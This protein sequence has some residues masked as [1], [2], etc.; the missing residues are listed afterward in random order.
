MA[1][2]SGEVRATVLGM[3]V[4]A[5][6][7]L[8]GHHAAAIEA[9]VGVTRQASFSLNGGAGAGAGARAGAGAGA[10][11]A[12]ALASELTSALALAPA[13]VLASALA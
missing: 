1:A 4:L 3:A 6:L 11:L 10:G 5:L 8:L 9:N 13:S 2:R 12:S 7:L